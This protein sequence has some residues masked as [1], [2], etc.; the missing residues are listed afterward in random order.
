MKYNDNGEYKEIVVKA[1][2]TLPV[3]TEVDF[4]G[5]EVPSGWS[6]VDDSWVA[7]ANTVYYKR[8][9]NV[10][11]VRGYSANNKTLEANDYTAVATL[12]EEIRPKIQ[13]G[14]PWSRIGEGQ[15]GI[16]RINT[17][18]VVELFSSTGTSYWAFTI[19]YII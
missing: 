19:T 14:F 7:V 2:D 8:S 3:G 18:G 6:A 11:C 5:N 12:P 15:V 10:V 17:T 4:D 13:L 9:G 16:T 1:T